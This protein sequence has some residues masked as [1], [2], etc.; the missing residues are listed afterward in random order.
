MR[1]DARDL[2]A[3]VDEA[4]LAEADLLRARILKRRRGTPL[5]DSVDDIAVIRA[6][7]R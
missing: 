2:T 7:E 5:S 6:G 1:R 3:P 4:S